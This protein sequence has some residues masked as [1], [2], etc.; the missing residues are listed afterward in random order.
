MSWL[1]ELTIIAILTLVGAILGQTL[2]PNRIP[3]KTE[4]VTLRTDDGERRLPK[5]VAGEGNGETTPENGTITTLEAYEAFQ[6]GRALFI[7]AREAD[8]YYPG[9][10]VG[11][12]HLPYQAFMDSL[13]YLDT[14][15]KD[16]LL[17]VYCDG[18]DC[19]ASLELAGD[20]LLMGFTQ[21]RSYFGG[22]Q[23]WSEAGYPVEG[24]LP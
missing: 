9:H 21:V 20:L 6:K 15:P 8:E 22:W 12:I 7:D 18:E 19:S 4:F 23:A 5:V 3:L 14:L 13:S 17:I 11:A 16:T 24:S 1:R 2:L 10:I